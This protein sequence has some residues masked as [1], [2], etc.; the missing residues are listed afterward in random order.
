[1]DHSLITA[2]RTTHIKIVV[3]ALV[4]AILVVVV[5]ISGHVS[6]AG[7]SGRVAVGVVKAGHPATYTSQNGSTVR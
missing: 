7:A 1:M 6:G 5:G 4:A 3:V 2:G